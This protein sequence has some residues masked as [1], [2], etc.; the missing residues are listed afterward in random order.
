MKK[1]FIYFILIA[2]SAIL[3]LSCSL[4]RNNPLD[5]LGNPDVFAPPV[6]QIDTLNTDPDLIKWY[7]A[8]TEED[9]LAD[10]YYI[11]GAFQ[12][13]YFGT[14]DKVG[15]NISAFDTTFSKDNVSHDY[16]WFKISSYNIFEG[17]TLEGKFSDITQ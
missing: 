14:F 7:V 11:Y 3:I 8:I 5:P 1:H 9:S 12:D 16:V 4:S 13:N 2:T 6:V 15:K 10:G 17:D